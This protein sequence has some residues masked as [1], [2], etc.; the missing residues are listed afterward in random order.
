M[1]SPWI[2]ACLLAGLTGLAGVLTGCAAA[3]AQAPAT[4]HLAG[5]LV[6]EGGP[7]GPGG[8]QP[9]E[10][11]I[12]GTVT[13]TAA[14]HQPVSVTAG[15]S[16]RFSVPLPP[17]RYQV[18]RRSPSIMETDGGKS[19]ELPCAQPTS[20]TVTAGRTTTITLTFVVP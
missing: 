5:R 18:C 10:R 11:P 19:R 8:Q 12:P 2:C 20:A 9:V 14:G 3:R 6:M 1:K 16:G 4:G 15:S 17:G 7:M 13:I